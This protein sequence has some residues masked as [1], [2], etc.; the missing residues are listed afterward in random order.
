M[1][2]RIVEITGCY[3]D[4]L[5]NLWLIKKW[6]TVVCMLMQ[7]LIIGTTRVFPQGFDMTLKNVL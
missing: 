4:H 3:G 7:L 5:N 2:P 1:V 6:S